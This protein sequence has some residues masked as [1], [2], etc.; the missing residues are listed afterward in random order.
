MTF[1]CMD[2]QLS[3]QQFLKSLFI[4]QWIALA[5]IVK[6]QLTLKVIIYIWALKSVPLIYMCILMPILEGLHY[7]G[8]I[9]SFEIRKYK[10][11][12]ALL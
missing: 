7:C 9:L 11:S 12:F 2:N 6:N 4:L 1:L 3:Q 10:S 8:F 5:H